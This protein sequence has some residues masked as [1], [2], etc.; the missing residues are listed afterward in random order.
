MRDAVR[1][2]FSGRT[3]RS[4]A[5]GSSSADGGR[6][7]SRPSRRM[8]NV[9]KSAPVSHGSLAARVN[10]SG[11]VRL[12]AWYIVSTSG[13]SVAMAHGHVAGEFVIT[14]S[15]VAR[16]N[17]ALFSTPWWP[18]WQPVRM[19]VWLARVTVGIDDMAPC[20]KLVPI[21]MR[22]AT[23]GASPASTA[24]WSTFGL[25]PS[26]RNPTTWSGRGPRS[27][28]TSVSTSPSWRRSSASGRAS[29]FRPTPA[30]CGAPPMT[31]STVGRH[32]D[33]P[34]G[35]RHPAEGP[36]PG[37][38][39]DERGPGLHHAHRAVLAPFAAVVLPVV[40]GGVHADDVGRGRVVEDLRHHL[41]GERVAGLRAVR[42]RRLPLVRQR[43]EA[44]GRLVAE[45]V[46]ALDEILVERPAGAVVGPAEAHPP[47]DGAGLVALDRRR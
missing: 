33:E 16:S 22:R 15:P 19:P 23:F 7:G 44:V 12:T 27:S 47:V 28:I 10:A 18:G 8:W 45:R 14:C 13:E 5:N 39:D 6:S 36:H 31:A 25:Q 4:V 1:Y 46:A 9:P 29:P 41:V 40:G 2:F 17:Q 32:V 24:S 11:Q 35:A 20:S 42:V 21:S 38:G 3:K 26:N 34:A 37:T 43:R 30:G